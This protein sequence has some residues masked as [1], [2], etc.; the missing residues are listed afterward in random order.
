MYWI[1]RL[2]HL[3][4]CIAKYVYKSMLNKRWITLPIDGIASFFCLKSGFLSDVEGF[5][6]RRLLFLLLLETVNGELR[7]NISYW[8][9][10][11]K[12]SQRAR[13]VQ[14]SKNWKFWKVIDFYRGWYL[15]YFSGIFPI[16]SWIM[17]PFLSEF[18]APS[19]DSPQPFDSHPALCTMFLGFHRLELSRVCSQFLL[20]I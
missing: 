8:I 15:K 12:S 3:K 2:L 7:N 17:S 20:L 9:F 13:S 19:L 18:Y 14:S 1:Y 10:F 5:W 11:K 4:R 6:V 16:L